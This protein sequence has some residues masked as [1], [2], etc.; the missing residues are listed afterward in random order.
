MLYN[1]S[2]PNLDLYYKMLRLS[3]T[4]LSQKVYFLATFYFEKNI[5]FLSL[6]KGYKNCT[7]NTLD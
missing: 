6:Q 5:L 1:S 3:A 7:V 4:S 2:I